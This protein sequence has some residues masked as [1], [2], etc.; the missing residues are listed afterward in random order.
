MLSSDQALFVFPDFLTIAT[1]LGTGILGEYF[2]F[3]PHVNWQ[4]KRQSITVLCLLHNTD[5]RVGTHL[6]LNNRWKKWS[7]RTPLSLLIKIVIFKII[8]TIRIVDY[9]CD[10][11]NIVEIWM[12]MREDR[13]VRAKTITCYSLHLSQAFL[14]NELQFLL[15]CNHEGVTCLCLTQANERT[16]MSCICCFYKAFFSVISVHFGT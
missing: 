1:I 14:K 11:L 16:L 9:N 10:V 12:W 3:L 4:S 7:R 15:D 5:F 13:R 8:K 6:M 2:Y